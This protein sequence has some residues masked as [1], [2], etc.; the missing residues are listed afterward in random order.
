MPN[1][2]AGFGVLVLLALGALVA[3]GC[4]DRSRIVD[5]VGAWDDGEDV[6]RF[7]PD[8]SFAGFSKRDPKFQNMDG[9][10]EVSGDTVTLQFRVIDPPVPD[11]DVWTLSA[12]G[13]T[14]LNPK[15]PPFQKI[16]TPKP[17]Q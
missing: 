13:R 10:W 15:G 4:R 1:A 11:P 3:G 17:S 16:G 14:L 9:Q 6:L 12:D 8:G 5:V 2:R 7:E